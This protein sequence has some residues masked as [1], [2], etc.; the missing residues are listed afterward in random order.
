LTFSRC[1]GPRLPMTAGRLA[2]S[3]F[4]Q[5]IEEASA[6]HAEALA[7]ARQTLH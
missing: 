7:A 5:E 6:L 2:I 4:L 1:F 3:I